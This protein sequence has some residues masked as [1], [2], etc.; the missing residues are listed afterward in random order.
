MCLARMR[1]HGAF[2]STLGEGTSLPAIADEC[3]ISFVPPPLFL[4]RKTPPP[5]A[6]SLPS[7]PQFSDTLRCPFHD[8]SSRCWEKIL[9]TEFSGSTRKFARKRERQIHFARSGA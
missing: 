7:V 6:V 5:V 9:P 2:Y 1:A 4:W 3:P 8:S